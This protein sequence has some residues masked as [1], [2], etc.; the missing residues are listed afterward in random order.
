VFQC[1]PDYYDATPSV[2]ADST[3]HLAVAYTFSTVAGGPKSLYVVTSGDGETWTTP[4]LVNSQGDSNFPQIASGPSPGDFRLAWQDNRTGQAR[5]RE[6]PWQALTATGRTGGAGGAAT[7]P[8]P[9]SPIKMPVCLV[10]R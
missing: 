1:Y 3:G 10:L 8:R 2:A 4:H 5:D 7:R 6:R 9:L